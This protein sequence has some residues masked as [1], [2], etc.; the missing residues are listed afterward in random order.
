MGAR[1]QH[2]GQDRE[3]LLKDSE[4]ILRAISSIA[5]SVS[6]VKTEL[7]NQQIELRE[8]KEHM[9]FAVITA[10]SF[11]YEQEDFLN[12]HKTKE[13]MLNKSP[14]IVRVLDKG[15]TTMR[16]MAAQ[17]ELKEAKR[18]GPLFHAFLTGLDVNAQPKQIMNAFQNFKRF[19][20]ISAISGKLTFNSK[21]AL[22]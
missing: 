16:E 20:S 15:R 21:S 19:E 11:G 9:E 12:L 8:I 6:T 5:R 13:I 17:G 1:I 7:F 22:E 2:S 4:E 18:K 14:L 3:G 10:E